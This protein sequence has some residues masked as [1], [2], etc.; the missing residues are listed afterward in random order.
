M[1]QACLKSLNAP[2]HFIGPSGL[3][4]QEYNAYNSRLFSLLDQVGLLGIG[5]GKWISGQV[6]KDL[7]ACVKKLGGCFKVTVL[8][9]AV[10]MYLFCLS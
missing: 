5:F 1:E 10:N 9:E 7:C 3:L 8:S 2:P 4:G 6:V